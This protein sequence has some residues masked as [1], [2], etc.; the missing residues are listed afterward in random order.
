M[1]PLFRCRKRHELKT[2]YD[3]AD[4]LND[5]DF[6]KTWF[7]YSLDLLGCRNKRQKV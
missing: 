1:I 7:N 6:C 3:Y 4:Y 5:H 2:D